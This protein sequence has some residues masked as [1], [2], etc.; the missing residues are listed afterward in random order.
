M[1]DKCHGV[2]IIHAPP[3][4]LVENNAWLNPWNTRCRQ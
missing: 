4:P 1:L 2:P 3:L